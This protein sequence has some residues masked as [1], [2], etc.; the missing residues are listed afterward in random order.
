TAALDVI[1]CA[2]VGHR[3]RQGHRAAALPAVLVQVVGDTADDVGRLVPQVAAAVV[4]EIHRIGFIAGGNELRPAHGTGIRAFSSTA[5]QM[6]G[7]AAFYETAQ[8]CGEEC[9]ARRV[10]ERKGGQCIEYAVFTD[11]A[12]VAGLETDDGGDDGCRYPVGFFRGVEDGLMLG[13]ERGAVAD[14]LL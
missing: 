4:I 7:Q 11:Y 9:R 6:L 1:E 10:I 13:N 2:V 3:G 14:A 12:P 8:L 5:V